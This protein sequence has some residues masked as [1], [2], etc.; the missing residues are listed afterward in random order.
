MLTLTNVSYT[1][2][3][4]NILENIS[5]TL[6]P[7]ELLLL[8]GKSGSGKTTLLRCIAQLI[9]DYTGAIFYN[10]QNIRELSSKQRAE[11]IGFVFQDFNLFKNLTVLENCTQPLQV[12]KSYTCEQAQQKALNFLKKLDVE[13]LANR[14]VY[15]LSGGQ[16]QRVA[17]ARALCFE[18]KVLCLDEPTSALD[19]ENTQILLNFLLSLLEA[20]T[21]IVTSSQDSYFIESLKQLNQ[22]TLFTL[23]S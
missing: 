4:K 16:Q 12:V 20:N 8:T 13:Q 22:S 2:N 21:S 5:L 17:L 19:T 11:T 3:N 7:G 9:E 15:E 23:K 18:P 6:N 1:K 14:Y 10:N